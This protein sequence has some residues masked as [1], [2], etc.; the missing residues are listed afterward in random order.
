LKVSLELDVLYDVSFYNGVILEDELNRKF[1]P[2]CGTGVQE[3]HN[4]KFT[5]EFN[6]SKYDK[7]IDTLYLTIPMKE[8]ITIKL[9]LN[10]K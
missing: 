7:N 6:L 5:F 3:E 4:S 9:Q 10:R 2:N 8:D 1:I